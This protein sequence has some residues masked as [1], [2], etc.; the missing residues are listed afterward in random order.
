MNEKR[1][2]ALMGLFLM[3]GGFII[4]MVLGLPIGSIGGPYVFGSDL[5][6]LFM[7]VSFLGLNIIITI[8]IAEGIIKETL[9]KSENNS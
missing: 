5:R 6:L 4:P 1:R 2:F 9:E 3:L 7:G 8:S